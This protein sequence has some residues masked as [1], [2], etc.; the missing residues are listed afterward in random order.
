MPHTYATVAEANNAI[1]SNGG[2]VLAT[3]VA[4][5]IADKLTVLEAV[6][7][8]IDDRAERSDFGSGFGPRVGTN[9]YDGCAGSRLRLH[10]DLLS[11]T[12]ATIRLTTAAVATTT[13]VTDTDYYLLDANDGYGAAP[14]RTLFLHRIGVSAF[15]SG[16]RVTDIT[17]TWGYA[18]TTE[19]LTTLGA[20]ITTTT[21]TTCTVASATNIV[22]GTMLLIDTE[23]VYVTSVSG[24]TVTISRGANGTTA[25]THL[26]AAAVSRYRYPSQ[27]VDVTTRLFLR[28]WKAR[29]AGADGSDGG[30][31]IPGVTRQESED[32]IIRRGL[33]GLR[34]K[35]MV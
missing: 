2:S 23:Q 18:N 5:K 33:F 7:R 20:A 19:A 35:E 6:S 15:G 29:D 8:L 12:S 26:N 30:G 4:A 21:A 9:R 1:I 13:L 14:Y 25:A 34:L 11:I 3:E 10:D 22:A 31:D 24:T 32:T 16:F 28:R 27:V 17:G